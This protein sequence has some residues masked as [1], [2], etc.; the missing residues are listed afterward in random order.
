M[1]DRPT[2]R[3]REK[4]FGDSRFTGRIPAGPGRKASYGFCRVGPKACKR[5][6]PGVRYTTTFL[7]L[8]SLLQGTAL[9]SLSRQ[10]LLESHWRRIRP[11]RVQSTA[12]WHRSPGLDADCPIAV[13]EST[14][15]WQNS[16]QLVG[17]THRESRRCGVSSSILSANCRYG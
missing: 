3:N 11:G 7:D 9:I 17:S 13:V 4:L 12:L 6:S 1:V 2:G 10:G 15:F 5:Q 14:F 16:R 8:I